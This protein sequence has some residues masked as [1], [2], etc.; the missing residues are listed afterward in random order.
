V[1]PFFNA[2]EVVVWGSG[3]GIDCSIRELAE[4]MAE[5]VGFR[6]KVVFDAGKPVGTPRKLPAVS[7]P[8]QLGWKAPNSLRDGLERT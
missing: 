7:L 6:G 2:A 1:S 8:R 4:T 5:V 3:S